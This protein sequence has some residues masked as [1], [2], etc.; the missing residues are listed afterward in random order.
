MFGWL[1]IVFLYNITNREYNSKRQN[2]LYIG[3]PINKCPQNYILRTELTLYGIDSI[4]VNH[5]FKICFKTTN[6]SSVQRSQL[7][8]LRR[9]LPVG[10]ILQKII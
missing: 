9:I 5:V 2:F 3:I 1:S 10:Y 6:D 8:I 7:R 4:S